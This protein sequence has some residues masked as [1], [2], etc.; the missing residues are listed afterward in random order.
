VNFWDALGAFVGSFFII[1][2]LSMLWKDNPVFKFG[3]QAIIGATIAQYVLFNMK[4]LLNMAI[5]PIS[6]GKWTYIIPVFLGLL[7]YTRLSPSYSWLSR[8]PV[9]VL[10]GVGVGVMVPGLLR[11]QVIGQVQKTI[12]DIT[13]ATTTYDLINA[14]IILIGVVT[15]ITFFLFTKEHTGVLGVSARI[16]RIFLMFSLGANWAGEEVWYLTQMIGRLRFIVEKLIK[17]VILGAA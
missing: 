4:N 9:S 13:S 7:M 10:V 14:I 17:G 1:S 15:A 3:Q 12:V 11:G 5:I 16:G 8:Y 2:V 6:Q